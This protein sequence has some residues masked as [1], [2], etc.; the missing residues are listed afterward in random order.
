M[1]IAWL[2]TPWVLWLIPPLVIP[3]SAAVVLWWHGRPARPATDRET[4]ASHR[5]YLDVLG[6]VTRAGNSPD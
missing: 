1:G 4:I 2:T 5:E 6:A 3:T